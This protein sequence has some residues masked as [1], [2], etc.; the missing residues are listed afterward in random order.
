MLFR[1]GNV[2]IGNCSLK[3][4]TTSWNNTA[5]GNFAGLYVTTG[6]NNIFLGAYADG[7]APGCS[8]TITLG[9]S[10]I[11]AIRAQVT[12]ITSLSDCRD[13]TDISSVPYGTN[14]LKK[15]RPVTFTWAM[16]DGGKVGQKETG[17]I[18]QELEEALNNNSLIKDWLDGLV[19]SNEDRSRLEASPGK[20]LPLV[21]KAIQELDE[22]LS[23]LENK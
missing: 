10:S 16:R 5:I 18:A 23:A 19:I 6:Y 4:Q 11:T 13:K 9:N 15:L 2:G 17:F 3:N 20:L 12:S 8:N 22:R 1:S 14:F 21:I 7:L